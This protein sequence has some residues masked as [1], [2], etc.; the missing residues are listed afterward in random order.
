MSGCE[1][2][3]WKFVTGW[4]GIRTYISL[5]P[6]LT[7]KLRDFVK[8]KDRRPW[9]EFKQNPEYIRAVTDLIETIDEGL[10]VVPVE[11]DRVQ[12]F[13]HIMDSSRV[14]YSWVCVGVY[15]GGIRKIHEVVRRSWP[16]ASMASWTAKQREF[17]CLSLFLVTSFKYY[18]SKRQVLLHDHSSNSPDVLEESALTGKLPDAMARDVERIRP[19]IPLAYWAHCPGSSIRIADGGTR[20]PFDRAAEELLSR[21]YEKRIVEEIILCSTSCRQVSLV[22]R[23]TTSAKYS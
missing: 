20:T 17:R 15:P 21:A 8:K 3:I 12:Y 23:K 10:F 13:V 11:W 4:E 9:R 7:H 2:W 16:A 6:V 18:S 19:F 22:R 1:G 5:Y 14:G